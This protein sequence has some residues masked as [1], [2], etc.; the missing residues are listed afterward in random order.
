M[1]YDT[2][3]QWGMRRSWWLDERPPDNKDDEKKCSCGDE[4]L[5]RRYP[6]IIHD[7]P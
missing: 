6:G 1:R 5:H 2:Y 4:D 7:D 3:R